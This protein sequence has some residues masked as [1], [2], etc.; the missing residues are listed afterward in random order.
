MQGLFG[1][2][3]GKFQRARHEAAKPVTIS[4]DPTGES[5]MKSATPVAIVLGCSLIAAAIATMPSHGPQYQIVRLTEGRI[6]RLDLHGG[7]IAYC[8]VKT[9][10]AERFIQCGP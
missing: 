8:S 5:P 4:E 1:T 2:G 9:D 10:N 3:N 6:A 7:T